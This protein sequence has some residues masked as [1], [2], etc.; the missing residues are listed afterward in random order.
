MTKL[1]Q[2][3]V[4]KISN[5]VI[6]SHLVSTEDSCSITASQSLLCTSSVNY[7]QYKSFFNV[8]GGT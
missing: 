7:A 3:K 8:E 1:A 4:Y 6:T 2:L 5:P